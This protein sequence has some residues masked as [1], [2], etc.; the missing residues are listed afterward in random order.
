MAIIG[1]RYSSQANRIAVARAQN[2]FSNSAQ[3]IFSGPSE[4]QGSQLAAAFLNATNTDGQLKQFVKQNVDKFS[5]NTLKAML[6][7]TDLTSW[8]QARQEAQLKALAQS[9]GAKIGAVRGAGVDLKA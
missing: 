9:V 3:E 5:G 2:R 7:A 1:S 4:T 8:Y 6:V